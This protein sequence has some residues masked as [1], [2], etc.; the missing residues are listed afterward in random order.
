MKVAV[1]STK[2]Y[3][4]ELLD[5]ANANRHQIVYYSQGLDSTTLGWAKN[6]D[7]LCLSISDKVD[8]N[9]IVKLSDI[10][11][12]LLVLRSAG[13]DNIDIAAAEKS[14]MAVMRVPS[15]SPESIAEHAAALVLSLARKIHKAF[16]RVRDN[17]F[18][19]DNLLGFT[20]SGKTVGVIGTGK[21]GRAFCRIM[22][23]FGCK[24]IAHDIKKSEWVI[25]HG[26]D[27]VSLDE[28]LTSSDIISLHCPLNDGTRHLFAKQNFD[29]C[30]RGFMLINTS[31]GGL[32]KTT[33]A[34]EA[35]KSGQVGN[36]G[37]DVYEGESGLFFK[38]LSGTVVVDDL[39]E[40]LMSFSNVLITPHQAFFTREAIEQIAISTIQ[41]ISNFED[42][43]ST[44][45]QVSSTNIQST[46]PLN[47]T[48]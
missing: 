25:N 32:I 21:I 13:F 39:I 12:N 40:R 31:R 17:N 2:F 48:R 37:I 34:A 14:K 7:A 4:Q 38:D 28:L 42:G 3:D 1:F 16:N 29:K 43:T 44:E 45:N 26:I 6:C 24:V 30:K 22:L 23:G 18:S 20:L 11:I 33:D 47:E 19:L 9:M 8:A 27:Y 15:Y 35:L 41:N 10:G 5:L 36:L 46:K